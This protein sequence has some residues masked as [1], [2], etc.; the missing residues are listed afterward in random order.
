ME[1]KLIP[2]PAEHFTTEPVEGGCIITG[3]TGPGGDVVI[4]GEIGGVKV[5]GIGRE[6]FKD[7]TSLT[8]VIIPEGVKKI[9]HRAFCGC[10]ALTSLVIPEGVTAIGLQ[11]FCGC[12]ALASLTIPESV[13]TL[14]PLIFTD[15][16]ALTLHVK[17][18]SLAHIIA[19]QNH[20]PFELPEGSVTPELFHAVLPDGTGC[21]I[22]GCITSAE[23]L[24]IPENI[25]G[26]PVAGIGRQAFL[27][28]TS[29]TSVSIP[30]GVT[31][32]GSFAFEGCT[33]LTSVSIPG[34]VTQIGAFAFDGCASLT[35]VIIP[36]SVTQIGEYAF[37][38]CT[39]LT[40]ISIPDSVT[41]ISNSVFNR[42]TSLTGVVIPESV[43]KIDDHA[44]SGCNDLTLHVTA[45]SYAHYH[46][47]LKGFPVGL[48]AGSV[49]PELFHAVL[50]D[51]AGC[52]IYG[53]ITAAETLRI[54]ESI[55]GLPVA[56]IGSY[57]FRLCSSL[58][59]VV[60]PEGVTWIGEGAFCAC[61][62]LTSVVIPESVTSIG[63][64]AFFYCNGLPS[65]VIPE[66]VT[67]IGDE[68]FKDCPAL[69]LR[70]HE[71]SCAHRYAVDNDL[72]FELL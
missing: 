41:E 67:Q 18:G 5:V 49:T 64:R 23:T 7:C 69:T 55:G 45:G 58:T 20:I 44:F 12:T 30:E 27:N 8:S 19:H 15:C 35:G 3:Y 65:I 2:S 71:G 14:V 43:T 42:C 70:V 39:A 17:A 21:T 36:D 32:I 28:C 10:T 52:I 56:G 33:A 53:C 26:L 25:G 4:P 48:P 46:A 6:A 68:A 34:S 50:P 24:R 9:F 1:N 72:P 62:A 29:L 11:V 54:P 40:S 51:G 31:E 16:P 47:L 63:V 61:F 37:S 22:I 38:G 59:S 13:T 57:A 60:I 66:G